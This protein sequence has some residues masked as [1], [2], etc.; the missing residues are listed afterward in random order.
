MLRHYKIEKVIG[1]GGFGITY[2]AFDTDLQRKVAIK[3]CYPRDFV[4]RQ[5][6]TV[7]PTSADDKTDFK[8]ALGKFVDEATTL[9]RFK[10][11][12]IVQVLQIL[13]GENGSAYM[14]LEFVE[15]QS[16]DDWLKSRQDPLSEEELLKIIHPLL[17]A[18]EVVHNNNLA[19]RDIAPDNIYIRTNGQAVLL[20]FGAARQTLSHQSRTLNLVVKDGY[21]AP[22][23]YYAEGRQ[24][25]W[26][27]IY[28]FAA[29]VYRAITGKKPVDAM[30]RLDAINNGDSDPLKSL[31]SLQPAG[32]S[33]PLLEA[34]DL[35]MAPQ[36]KS[37]PKSLG[38]W[39]NVLLPSGDVAKSRSSTNKKKSKVSSSKV[40]RPAQS[41]RRNRFAAKLAGIAILLV[42]AA[43]GAYI[44]QKNLAENAEAKAWELAVEADN[45][46]S[47]IQ[48]INSFPSSPRVEDARAALAA[49]SQPW[50]KVYGGPGPDKIHAIAASGDSIV[51]VGGA[52]KRDDNGLQGLVMT[53][54]ASGKPRWETRYGKKGNDTFH[55]VLI[56][57]SGNIVAVGQS[58]SAAGEH[59]DGIVVSYS[60]AGKKQWEKRFGGTGNDRLLAISPA[61]SGDFLIAGSTNS[62]GLGGQDGWLLRLNRHGDLLQENTYGR[63]GND[64]LMSVAEMAN[65]Q[66]ALAGSVEP[67]R[68]K[69]ANFWVL[70]VDSSGSV[71]LDRSPGGAARDRLNAV[72]ARSDGHIFL[73]G[74]T[75]SFGTDS[76]DG[77]IM[78]VTPDNKM[79]PKVLSGARE[80]YLLDITTQDDG[81]LL[82]AGYTSSRGAG[83]A[84]AWIMKMN[85]DLSRT[86]WERVLG[87]NGWDTANAIAAFPDGS[88]V[89]AGSTE[90]GTAGTSDAWIVRLSADGRSSDD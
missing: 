23:Q 44:Y 40:P 30:A 32:F 49:L 10:H 59:S 84:D 16:F 85:R 27:D 22:E 42:A 69:P 54:S 56:D 53:L 55:D 80:D 61:R 87:G 19:H 14:V 5:G 15:G 29:T 21:S 1:Q 50:S 7:I 8:W 58:S 35:A 82:I 43:G 70:K 68:G 6:T 33:K 72:T 25:A 88:V 81:S 17:D 71:L 20:D 13:K 74:E 47:Y 4:S 12:G 11:P 36:T 18:L 28:G 2:L 77:M 73:V 39:R 26:T 79:P 67:Q 65:G 38:E 3:E 64:V 89:F 76:S 51:V 75:R 66:I 62:I 52:D 45:R 83:S 60:P 34:I 57:P 48:F 24:G 78:S 63:D 41:G 37:R 9:A 90:A 86:I 31:A 46:A